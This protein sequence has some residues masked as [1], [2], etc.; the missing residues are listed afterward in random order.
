MVMLLGLPCYRFDWAN[1]LCDAIRLSFDEICCIAARRDM[2]TAPY[3]CEY[4]RAG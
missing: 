2:E 3:K 1:N 4:P